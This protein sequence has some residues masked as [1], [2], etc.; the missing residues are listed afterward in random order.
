MRPRQSLKDKPP[1]SAGRMMGIPRTSRVHGVQTKQICQQK[2]PEKYTVRQ[3]GHRKSLWGGPIIDVNQR[4]K[5]TGACNNLVKWRRFL[6]AQ[7][8]SFWPSWLGCLYACPALP[9]IIRPIIDVIHSFQDLVLSWWTIT[10]FQPCRDLS[11]YY[12]KP[13]S[14]ITCT[15]EPPSNDTLTEIAFNWSDRW[16]YPQIYTGHRLVGKPTAIVGSTYHNYPDGDNDAIEAYQ[17]YLLP[18]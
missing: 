5:R 2:D 3:E 10:C 4:D 9:F 7:K 18:A 16:V 11:T 12:P 8:S 17:N 6:Q 13:L 14:R 1:I 15:G